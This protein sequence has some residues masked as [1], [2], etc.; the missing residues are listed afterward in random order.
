[1][2]KAADRLFTRHTK[3]TDN[4]AQ[5]PACWRWSMLQDDADIWAVEKKNRTSIE[6]GY[7]QQRAEWG[8]I[9]LWG[10]TFEQGCGLRV[11]LELPSLNRGGAFRLPATYSSGLGPLPWPLKPHWHLVKGGPNAHRGSVGQGLTHKSHPTIVIETMTLANTSQGQSSKKDFTVSWM[12]TNTASYVALENLS[13]LDWMTDCSSP[14]RGW[15]LDVHPN[16]TVHT[17]LQMADG[18]T[19]MK[20]GSK[21][22]STGSHV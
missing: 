22:D 10:H 7:Y 5:G 12:R 20:E 11:L 9:L 15:G 21:A 18:P 19:E 17:S 8:R 14:A 4:E 6:C 3:R 16:T 2:H 13:H 1:M